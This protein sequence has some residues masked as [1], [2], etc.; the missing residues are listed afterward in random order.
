MVSFK[1]DG[2][3]RRIAA[4]RVA[5]LLAT[6]GSWPKGVVRARNGDDDDLRPENLILT[7]AGPQ[8]F[9]IGRGGKASS[10]ATRQERSMAVLKALAQHPGSTVP[11]L[12]QLVGMTDSCCCTRLGKLSDA[13]LTCGPKCDARARWELTQQGKAL[14]AAPNPVILDALD[15]SILA[16][17]VRASAGLVSISRQVGVCQL[18]V[19]RRAERLI[20]RGLVY[21][22]LRGFYVATEAGRSTQGE[23]PPPK[24]EPWLK[25]SAISAAS[26]K[27]VL[28]RSTDD[29][30]TVQKAHHASHGRAAVAE[31][32]RLRR[33]RMLSA[34]GEAEPLDLTG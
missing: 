25:V 34:Y 5:W 22:D 28:E 2:H 1:F 20:K 7:K 12:S 33:R 31:T 15:E 32:M 29:R 24:P 10:L 27:D 13:G 4:S 9:H 18:T 26:A 11:Q 8:P 17:L 21:R 30:T 16:A 3:L 6:G 14:A 19:K 23:A